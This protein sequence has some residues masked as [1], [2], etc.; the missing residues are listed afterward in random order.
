MLS[1]ATATWSTYTLAQAAY[2][3]DYRPAEHE[4]N[5]QRQHEDHHC[6][7]DPRSAFRTTYQDQRL[8]RVD[9]RHCNSTC[10]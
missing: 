1:T 10:H 2:R 7:N 5:R 8:I 6:R 9:G 3:E 4:P